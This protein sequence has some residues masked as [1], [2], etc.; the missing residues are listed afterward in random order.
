VNKAAAIERPARAWQKPY[1]LILQLVGFVLCCAFL[2]FGPDLSWSELVHLTGGISRSE[3]TAGLGPLS[4]QYLED[5]DSDDAPP[6]IA[7]CAQA[8]WLG[9]KRPDLICQ[10]ITENLLQGLMGLRRG[11]V[12]RQLEASGKDVTFGLIYRSF[13]TEDDIPDWNG[14]ENILKL[15]FSGG[16]VAFVSADV[17]GPKGKII[18][19]RRWHATQG[20][21]T[22]CSD[23]GSHE[24]PC[25]HS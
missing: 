21:D 17:V 5:I 20:I 14:R 1:E 22:F 6:V 7:P 16:K 9:R 8:T 25:P 24:Y 12:A 18:S 23:F 10:P 19:Y 15:G 3:F 4:S 13:T 11:S 2:Y